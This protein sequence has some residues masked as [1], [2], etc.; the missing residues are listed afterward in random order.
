VKIVIICCEV[1]KAELTMLMEKTGIYYPVIWISSDY[2]LNPE[3]LR[4]KLQSEIDQVRDADRILLCYGCCGNAIIGLK[5]TTADL[6]FFKTEDCIEIMLTKPNTKFERQKAT[7]FLSKG[8]LEG[9]KSIL[10]EK[11]YM[12]KRY[13]RER[14]N[15]ILKTMLNNYRYLLFIDSGVADEQAF[16]AMVET[17]GQFA[18]GMDLEFKVEKSDNWLLEQFL[19]NK[20]NDKFHL[21]PKGEVITSRIFN[22]G[23]ENTQEN[24]LSG[25]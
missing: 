7:Y 17:C 19:L 14:A 1:L 20:P 25:L 13:G 9:T 16:N 4:L 18:A 12:I 23:Q 21:L 5:A 10:K 11:E 22:N 6:L 2:H 3:K 8:W 24:T 15:K